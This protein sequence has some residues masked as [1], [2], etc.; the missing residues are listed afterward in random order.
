MSSVYEEVPLAN[1]IRA[2]TAASSSRLREKFSVWV[3][4]L[5]HFPLRIPI[6]LFVESRHVLLPVHLRL[7]AHCRLTRTHTHTHINMSGC[8]CVCVR[9]LPNCRFYYLCLYDFSAVLHFKGS[10]KMERSD[11]DTRGGLFRV[12]STK[13]E[14]RLQ[15]H[16]LL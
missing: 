4:S 11:K 2:V 14:A 9:L 6:G 3:E 1:G 16:F 12:P 8:A 10:W 7:C 13:C 15:P 5:T